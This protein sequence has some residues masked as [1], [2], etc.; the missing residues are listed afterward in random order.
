MDTPQGRDGRKEVWSLHGLVSAG[1]LTIRSHEPSEGGPT[2]RIR[3][4]RGEGGGHVRCTLFTCI[5]ARERLLVTTVVV[6][7]AP[8]KPFTPSPALAKIK[9]RHRL[10]KFPTSFALTR[11]P[12]AAS[13]GRKKGRTSLSR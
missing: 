13:K 12:V 7:L 8:V 11:T 1:N 10:P 4:G 6:L 9:K 5:G 2:N 3:R